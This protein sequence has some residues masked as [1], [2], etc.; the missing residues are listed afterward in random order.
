LK[1]MFVDDEVNV[2]D[3]LR[4]SMRS[5][6]D[7]WDMRFAISGEDALQQLL[8][9]PADVVVSDMRMPG[10]DGS[11]L[12]KEVK[13]LYPGTIRFILSGHAEPTAVLQAAATAHQYLS[14]PCDTIILKTAIAR[15]QT[16]KALLSDERIAGWAGE[17]EALPSLPATY[18][19]IVACL[20]GEDATIKDVADVVEE[21]LAMSTMV[22]KL[23]NSA[24][25]GAGQHVRTTER[26]VSFLGI[27]NVAALVLAHGAFK[28]TVPQLASGLDIPRLWQHSLRTAAIARTLALYEKW[29]AIRADDAFLAGMLHDLGSVVLA[30]AA[31]LPSGDRPEGVDHAQVGA[32]LVGLWGFPDPLVEAIA[33]HHEPSKAAEKGI[34]LPGLLHAANLL[35]NANESGSDTATLPGIDTAFFEAPGMLEKWQQWQA[36]VFA[37]EAGR[38]AASR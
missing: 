27:D 2:L 22:L 17:A 36:C 7:E 26:A 8:Q 11:Q 9:A 38:A 35:A 15:A 37:K 25:F 4:R 29:P 30:T 3:G 20:Q 14:K 28:P 10:L 34:T 19:R 5:M 18:Q 6:R 21:D 24:F 33:F 1:I 12:L 13:R 16:L 32:Y 31:A 23:A